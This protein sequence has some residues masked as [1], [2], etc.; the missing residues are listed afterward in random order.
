VT[1]D[2][3]GSRPP[4]GRPPAAPPPAVPAAGPVI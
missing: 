4:P 3:R 2:A 1:L